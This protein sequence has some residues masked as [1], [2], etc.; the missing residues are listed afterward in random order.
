[1]KL[2]EFD[3]LLDIKR[4]K[5]IEEFEI[6]QGDYETNILKISLVE[7][8][9]EYE[10][11]GLNVEIAF[12]KSDGTTVLQ[13]LNNG[14]SLV[15]NKIVCTLKTN[16]IASPGKVLAEVRVLQDLK[17][18]TSSRF[19]FFVRQSII[20]DETIES[21]NEFPILNQLVTDVNS[22]LDEI[23]SKPEIQGY[24]AYQVWLNQGNIGTVDD[25]LSSLIGQQGK[26]IEFNWEGKNLGVRIEGEE[27][28]QYIDLQGDK[29]DIGNG[30]EYKWEGT[31]LGVREKGTIDYTYVDLRGPTGSIENLDKGNIEDALGYIPIRSVNNELPDIDGNVAMEVGGGS[32]IDIEYDNTESELVAADVQGAIDETVRAVN[33]HK[34]EMASKHIAETGSNA[35]GE[36]IKFDDGTMICRKFGTSIVGSGTIHTE[37]SITFPAGFAESPVVTITAKRRDPESTIKPFVGLVPLVSTSVINTLRIFYCDGSVLET[38]NT[39]TFDVV[40]IGRWK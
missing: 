17:L 18:L 27:E 36:Y 5:K 22:L 9:N 25:F 11:S 34:A 30:L 1:M 4:N 39:F 13:D 7:D 38:S 2:K 21:T 35:N 8:F 32:A 26:S 29:G 24:S 12:A 37:T 31:E 10:L 33:S 3:I 28:Y 19:S 14:I 15:G 23:Q 20:N 6:V 16:T 40:A